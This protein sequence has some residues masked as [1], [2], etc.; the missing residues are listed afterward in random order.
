[1]RDRACGKMNKKVVRV[2][3]GRFVIF[4]FIIYLKNEMDVWRNQLDVIN[5][6]L[7]I[8]GFCFLV[9]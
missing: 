5:N 4:K 1:M 9:Y 8:I 6:S 2:E 3:E 7:F